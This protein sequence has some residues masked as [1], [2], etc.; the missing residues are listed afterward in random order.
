MLPSRGGAARPAHLAKWLA[1]TPAAAQRLWHPLGDQLSAVT[2][3][4]RRAWMHH[5]ALDEPG[6]VRGTAGRR[7]TQSCSS[8]TRR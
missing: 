1:L 3:E 6:S 2:V 8:P 7:A 4:E 5:Q